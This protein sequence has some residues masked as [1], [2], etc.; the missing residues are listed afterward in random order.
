MK[1][2]SWPGGS[3]ADPARREAHPLVGQ[4]LHARRQIVD[5]QPDVV[6]RRDVDLRG[7]LG[8]ERLHQVDLHRVRTGAE[9]Q[10]VLVDVLRLAHV[11]ADLVDAEQTRSTVR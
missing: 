1:H 2:T 4:P 11:V 9:A 10:D 5:P 7:A 6:Q 3:L 8:I